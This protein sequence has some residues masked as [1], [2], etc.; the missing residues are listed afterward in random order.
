MRKCYQVIHQ[1]LK[2]S[3]H[4]TLTHSALYALPSLSNDATTA[5]DGFWAQVLWPFLQGKPIHFLLLFW[6]FVPLCI[7]IFKIPLE[8]RQLCCYWAEIPFTHYAY[9]LWLTHC[10][11]LSLNYI[12]FLV[13]KEIF[14][15]AI[16]TQNVNLFTCSTNKKNSSVLGEQHTKCWAKPWPAGNTQET[17][18]S[19]QNSRAEW[20]IPYRL[21]NHFVPA[22]EAEWPCLSTLDL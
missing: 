2:L 6:Q 5:A 12:V 20:R 7:C 15:T 16:K 13:S 21:G 3:R 1:C 9:S 14:Y 8:R 17:V 19:S 22:S 4:F 11:C 10:L 18:N